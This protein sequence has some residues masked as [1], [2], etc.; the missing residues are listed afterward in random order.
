M[1][2]PPRQGQSGS[3][4]SASKLLKQ[5]DLSSLPLSAPTLEIPSQH[6]ILR[7]ETG[8]TTFASPDLESPWADVEQRGDS[9]ED[10]NWRGALVAREHQFLFPWLWPD[11]T[12]AT[13]ARKRR[14]NS[15]GPG[16]PELQSSWKQS[17]P[18]ARRQPEKQ[19]CL[20]TG[21]EEGGSPRPNLAQ[22]MSARS[23]GR[24][25]DGASGTQRMLAPREDEDGRQPGSSECWGWQEMDGLEAWKDHGNHSRRGEGQAMDRE[26]REGKAELPGDGPRCV[27]ALAITWDGQKGALDA[28][29][30][31]TT[32]GLAARRESKVGEM[33]LESTSEGRGKP[34]GVAAASLCPWVLLIQLLSAGLTGKAA[35]P[36]GCS[37]DAIPP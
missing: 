33:Q 23:Q 20:P 30:P 4:I 36:E 10:G 15:S 16:P 5:N 26:G 18:G 24:W 8:S 19:S 1:G 17:S 25:G 14:L 12:E 29:I 34:W 31:G 6:K 27:Y 11:S 35:K 2:N 32:L 3:E 21:R 22:Q 9:C 28:A 37:R 7:V 13:G